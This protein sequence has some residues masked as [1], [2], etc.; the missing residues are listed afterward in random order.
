MSYS[1]FSGRRL[2]ELASKLGA[3]GLTP[4][5]GK[6]NDRRRAWIEI[7]FGK[8]GTRR[9]AVGVH[10]AA[11]T[12]GPHLVA[13]AGVRTMRERRRYSPPSLVVRYIRFARHIGFAL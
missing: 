13:L 8:A 1:S 3:L 11:I 9:I 6:E 4:P 7:R 5:S 12:K 10:A 2:S